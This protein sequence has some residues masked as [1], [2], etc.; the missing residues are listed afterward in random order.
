MKTVIGIDPGLD[1]WV[2]RLAPNPDTPD[3]YLVSCA[4][5]PV[6]L[7]KKGSGKR[8]YLV[9]DMA[10]LIASLTASYSETLVI[11]EKQQAMRRRFGKGD[12]GEAGEGRTQGVASAFSTGRGYGLWEGILAG[13]RVPYSIV[14]PRTWQ[15]RVLRDLPGDDTKARSIMACGRLFPEIDLRATE[16]CRKPDHNKADSIL[17]AFWGLTWGQADVQQTLPPE[18]EPF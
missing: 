15:A 16:R 12:D 14:H 10:L 3:S 8:D 9:N 2:T 6:C 18:E 1:G 11:L 17:L 13:L 5:T 4:R 7:V